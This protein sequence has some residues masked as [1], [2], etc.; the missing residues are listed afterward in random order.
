MQCAFDT[1][2]FHKQC[3]VMVIGY[4]LAYLFTCR[5]YHIMTL[6]LYFKQQP[7]VQVTKITVNPEE[8]LI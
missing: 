4:T 7:K 3:F 8:N 2:D 1:N 6:F 5:V